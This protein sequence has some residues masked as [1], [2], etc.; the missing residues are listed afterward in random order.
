MKRILIALFATAAL[1]GP[2]VAEQQDPNQKPDQNNG[3]N[4][5]PGQDQNAQK[6]QDP[7]ID[8]GAQSGSIHLTRAQTLHAAAVL[9]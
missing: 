5:N 7:S 8:K 6:E 1:V 3:Q 4:Q 2:A 9:E